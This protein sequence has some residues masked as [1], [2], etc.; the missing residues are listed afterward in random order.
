MPNVRFKSTIHP[1]GIDLGTTY[2]CVSYLTP[3]GQPVTL[4]NSSGEMATPS[5][6]FFVGDEI[7][8]GTE[9]LRQSVANPERVISQ[10]KRHM[11]DPNKCWVIDGHVYR[12]R[13]I[14]SYILR[15][16]L[17]A[18]E[19]RLGR[20]HHAVI[21]VPAQFSDLQ[22][23]DTIEAAYAAGLDRVD[24]INEPVAAALCYV[25]SDGAWFAEIANEQTILVFDLG[26]GTFDL[27]L[28]NFHRDIDKVQVIASGGDLKLGGLDWNQE[29]I[30]FACD[31]FVR[32]SISDPRVD[33][34]SMQALAIEVE[35]AKRSLSVRPRT[36]LVVQHDGRRKTYTVNR[37]HFE[38]LTHP[39]V[40]RAEKITQGMLK[41]HGLGWAKVDSLLVTGG[42]S[43]MPMVRAMLQRISGT[44]LNN[45]LN[46][47]QSISHGAAYYAGMLLSGQKLE[48]SS[49]KSEATARLGAMKQQSV[50]GRA[51]GLLIRDMELNERRPHYVIPANTP[52][53][54]AFRQRFGTIADNQK[55]VFL[56][57]IES[58][59][60]PE[61]PPVEIGECAIAELP[62]DLPAKSPIEV[63][64]RYTDQGRIEVTAIDVTSGQIAKT[65]II[66]ATEQD[67]DG[68]V[69]GET[70]TVADSP[71]TVEVLDDPQP[72]PAPPG[73]SLAN[74]APPKP[75]PERVTATGS[76]QKTRP[77]VR[78]TIS[79]G[80][81]PTVSPRKPKKPRPTSVSL[82]KAERPVP[83]CNR[84]G[85]PLN[86]KGHCPRCERRRQQSA[87]RPK[88]S[89]PGT[90]GANVP[91]EPLDGILQVPS[92]PKPKL[93][94]K[95]D[96]R[97][98]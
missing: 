48:K 23:Q 18:A 90:V 67:S 84:C 7:I 63:T 52:L 35:Q 10:A 8:V 72:I 59:T 27:S 98:N 66:R 3:Q 95:S 64:M 9:A 41:A 26:G 53:P 4:P 76:T 74:A 68:T 22:R 57:I 50:S 44:T 51:L 32:E 87:G 5:I 46:P 77:K 54:C 81:S 96:Q 89:G 69:G 29:L 86:H 15:Y 70:R 49:L 71:Q 75:K 36:T 6:V 62:D 16:L 19:D 78:P 42:A 92:K 93:R 97:K 85:E 55:T 20:I 25:L 13:E 37:D 82:E 80:N 40:E 12:P 14:S 83:L 65:T 94:R 56:Q 43:R 60:N 34:E 45:S 61:D 33:R 39:L 2:S 11:G 30:D 17:D 91:T 38:L 21:T 28:V 79:E 31:Q 73:V 24:I 1:V 58:G 47:D 88:N